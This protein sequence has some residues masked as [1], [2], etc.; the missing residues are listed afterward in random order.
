MTRGKNAAIGDEN[1]AAN[2]YWYVR[3]AEGWRL[4]HHIVAEKKYKRDIDTR[5]DRVVFLDGNRENFK[6][7]NIE[8]RVRNKPSNEKKR[9]ALQARIEELQAQLEELE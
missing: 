5:V 2:G 1:Q 6:P 9:A 7:S 8:I 3:T 4:K